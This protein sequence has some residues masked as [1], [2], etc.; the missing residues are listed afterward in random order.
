LTGAALGPVLAHPLVARLAASLAERPGEQLAL[1]D[2]LRRAAVALIIRLTAVG[3]LEFLL[4][5]RAEYAGDPWSGQIALP[6]GRREPGDASLVDTAIRETREETGID[7]AAHGR[8]IGRLDELQPSN[9]VLP[10]IAIAPYVAV[11]AGP[12][13]TM[14]SAEVS[15]V[16]WVPLDVLRDARSWSQVTIEIRGMRREFPGFVYE[17]NVVWGLTERILTQFLKRLDPAWGNPARA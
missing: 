15:G 17:G 2:P 4:I 10:A 12:M 5:R 9:P 8:I 1:S 16:F 6:G 13:E 3:A 11:L 14:L 7:L